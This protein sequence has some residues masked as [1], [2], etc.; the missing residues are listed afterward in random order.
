MDDPIHNFGAQKRKR[1]VSFK[2][3]MDATPEVIGEADQHS[4]G[5]G[6]KE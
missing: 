6:S 5:R 4:T 3:A 1:G 2:Q